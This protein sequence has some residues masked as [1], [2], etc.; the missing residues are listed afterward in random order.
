MLTCLVDKL[1]E[2]LAAKVIA[3]AGGTRISIPTDIAKSRKRKLLEKRFTPELAAILIFHFGG[4]TLY[5]PTATGTRTRI[6]DAVVKTMTRRNKSAN[7]IALKLK[8]SERAVYLSRRRSRE[9]AL[10]N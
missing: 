8:C 10:S 1:G 5:V 7:D 3:A 4:E 2:E 6:S 9:A